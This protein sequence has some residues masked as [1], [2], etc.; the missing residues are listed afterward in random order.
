MINYLA[1]KGFTVLNWMLNHQWKIVGGLFLAAFL[2]G[3]YG[4]LDVI[5]KFPDE[6]FAMGTQNIYFNAL[7]LGFLNLIV[8]HTDNLNN[9]WITVSQALAYLAITFVVIITLLK[10]LVAEWKLKTMN[11]VSHSLLKG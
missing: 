6:P 4:F 10:K 2:V 7:V 3:S 5:P 9:A 11:K 1:H 8:G